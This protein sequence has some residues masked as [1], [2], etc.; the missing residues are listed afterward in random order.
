MEAVEELRARCSR[1]Y[2]RRGSRSGGLASR[3]LAFYSVAGALA[4]VE[5][6]SAV[7]RGARLYLHVCAG[8]SGGVLVPLLALHTH[9]GFPPH[10]RPSP[11]CPTAQPT[12]SQAMS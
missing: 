4:G 7:G 1:S 8:S 3:T 12:Y 9:A 5:M 2:S 11:V 6:L 10:A